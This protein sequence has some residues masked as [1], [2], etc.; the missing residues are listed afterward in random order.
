MTTYSYDA[1]DR[2]TGAITSAGSLVQASATTYDVAGRIISQT[3]GG[4]T[5][6]TSYA[7]GGLTTTTTLPNGTTQ[8]T[9]KYVDGQTKST[10]GSGVVAN[11]YDYQVTAGGLRQAIAYASSANSPRTQTTTTD[12]MGRTVEQ[13]KPACGGGTFTTTNVYNSLGQLT[14][15]TQTGLADTLYVYDASGN[16]NQ[17]GLDMD[18]DGGLGTG[19]SDRMTGTYGYYQPDS[20]HFDHVAN[21]TVYGDLSSYTSTQV[22][23]VGGLPTNVVSK[24]STTDL[25]GNATMVTTTVDLAHKL[26]TTTTLAPN[27]TNPAVQVAYNGLLVSTSTPVS[28][29]PA[30]YTYDA[31]G[32][33]ST[34][35]DPSTGAVTTT[36][37][38]VVYGQTASIT[39]NGGGLTSSTVNAYYGNNEA[40]PGQLKSTMANGMTTNYTYTPLNQVSGV[41]GNT[42]PLAYTYDA[43]GAMQTLTTYGA[44]G[45]ATTTWV[46]D[47]ATGLIQQKLDASQHGASYTY[48]PFGGVKTRTWARGT[49]TNYGYDAGGTL[50]SLSYSDGVTPSV[51]LTNGRQGWPISVTDAAGTH[52]L[53]Y[54]PDGQLTGDTISGSGVLA[55]NSV[56]IGYDSLLRR[57]AL[58]ASNGSGLTYSVGYSYDPATGNLTGVIDNVNSGIVQ[59]GFQPNS[60]RLATTT[61]NHGE[62]PRLT[63]T[64]VLD[65]LGRLSSITNT[66]S[67]SAGVVSSHAY[68]YNAQGQRSTATLA[69]GSVWTY[70]YNTNGELT[71]GHHAWSSGSTAVAGQQ[72]D[73]AYDGIGNRTSTTINGRSATYTANALNQYT[74]RQVPG[75]VDVLGTAD[76]GATVTVNTL[77][78]DAHQQGG[79]F[80]KALGAN[81]AG[82]PVNQSIDVLAVKAGAGAGGADVVS[83]TQGSV[84]VPQTPESFGYDLDGNMTQDGRWTYEWDG[85]NRLLQMSSVSPSATYSSRNLVFAYD[86]QNHRVKKTVFTQGF[87][88]NSSS[89]TTLFL[90]DEWNLIAELGVSNIPL[91]TYIWG[92]DLSGSLQGAGGVGGLLVLNDYTGINGAHSCYGCY[93]GS[94]NI[95]GIVD[96]A[97][98]NPSLLCDYGPFG[99]SVETIIKES[100]NTPFRFSTKYTDFETG[101]SIYLRP[102]QPSLGA[103]LSRDPMWESGG[104]NLYR[105]C[106]NNALNQIDALGWLPDTISEVADLARLIL[107]S[108]KPPPSS[109]PIPA[110]PG[111]NQPISVDRED[112]FSPSQWSDRTIR[113]SWYVSYQ[114]HPVDRG[115]V[116]MT[117]RQAYAS[118]GSVGYA[119]F[120]SPSYHPVPSDQTAIT[121]RFV[122]GG[123]GHWTKNGWVLTASVIDPW[124]IQPPSLS[125]RKSRQQKGSIPPDV[126]VQ[127]NLGAGMSAYLYN[128]SL[129]PARW[130]GEYYTKQP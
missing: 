128:G 109:S 8:V 114:N 130:H 122:C 34:A 118:T 22:E 1:A 37:Y 112:T 30:L 84:F 67:S 125:N 41:S 121:F 111:V 93:D 62:T 57:N 65:G 21:T 81:N 86:W 24:V 82:G 28:P 129:S 15:T 69:D 38:D 18:G 113:I 98:G 53:T 97:N 45:A 54:T 88:Q 3:Q 87:T 126:P 96:A 83:D 59:Y 11:F 124:G 76:P 110:P 14:K 91:R 42:Y 2:Q 61:I 46:Y 102:Y 78:I 39:T 63:T 33:L 68:T 119:T 50:S 7:N 43:N 71:G 47:A 127:N 90:C 123:A 107:S 19:S 108:P 48:W 101:L 95:V 120:N 9:S 32:R 29:T 58:S 74:S 52:A 70:G 94:G 26:V 92:E 99:E 10:T 66:A 100:L 117:P 16:L 51:S 89:A 64:R 27:A 77:P 49:V 104:V 17:T 13:D 80:Y 12:G 56:S 73:Y 35:S 116:V 55:G 79:Y 44:A 60:N 115:N 6:S 75:A 4:L 31:L 23:Q 40:S 103:W 85:E 20:G 72:F 106:S 5:T 36:T 25:G 105:F